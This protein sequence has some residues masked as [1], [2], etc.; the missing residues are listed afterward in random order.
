[1]KP[2]IKTVTVNLSDRS[3]PIL[4]GSGILAQPDLWLPADAAQRNAFIITDANVAPYGEM[5][6]TFLQGKIAGVQSFVLPAGE[7]TKSFTLFQETLEWLLENGVNRKSFIIALGGGVIGDLAGYCA[8]SVLR[9]IDFIQIPTTLLAQVDSSVGGKT[10]IN[11]TQ[12]KNLIGAF[13]QPKTVVIDLEV[14]K[15]LPDREM[16]AGYAEIAKYGLLG[17]VRFFDWLE[18]NGKDVLAKNADALAHAIETSCK[19]KAEIVRQDER[20]ETG[21]RALLNLGHTFAHAL[22]TACEYD[23]RLLHG[24]AVGIGL[25]QAARLSQSQNMISGEDVSRIKAHLQAL[26]MMTEISDISP[27]VT[28]T[29]EQLLKLMHKDKKATADGIGFIVLQK[30]GRARIDKTVAAEQVLNI[31]QESIH[32]T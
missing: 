19:M 22:E 14:L 8:A 24:E 5:L 11:S 20:E 4:I 10:G 3:Y 25:V 13:Y 18:N 28:A 31:L 2:D 32:G 9:G 23:G 30:L 1:M 16:K 12:G 26:G 17:D 27:V 7:Q 6:Q 15:T 21:L 29:P